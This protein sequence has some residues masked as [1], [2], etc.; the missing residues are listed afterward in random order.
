MRVAVDETRCQGH[1]LCVMSAPRLFA[2]DD[3]TGRATVLV[4]EL[5]RELVDDADSAAGNCPEEAISVVGE[6]ERA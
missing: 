3:D 5:G 6:E 4:P 2:V 1:G